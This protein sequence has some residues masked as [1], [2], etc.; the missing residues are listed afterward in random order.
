MPGILHVHHIVPLEQVSAG[1]S[2][3]FDFNSPDNL[4]CICPNCHS[5]VHKAMSRSDDMDFYS[6][7]TFYPL[8]PFRKLCY[9]MMG[10]TRDK[11]EEFDKLM[12]LADFYDISEDGDDPVNHQ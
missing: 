10:I 6:L 4:V 8:Q 7:S 5:V 2:K 11:W 9:L 12:S 1:W 3:D